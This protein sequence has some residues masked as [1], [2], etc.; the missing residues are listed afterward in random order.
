V[1]SLTC[2]HSATCFLICVGRIGIAI[3]PR[4]W[5]AD[6]Y[7][8]NVSFGGVVTGNQLSGAFGYGIAASSAR[9]FTIQDNTLVGNTTFIGSRGPNCSTTDITPSPGP[10]VIQ[11]NNTQNMKVQGN[12]QTIPDGDGLT[13]ILPPD[14]GDYWPFG[15]NPSGGGG[16]SGSDGS[17]S[18]NGGHSGGGLSGGAKAGI[19]LGVI[20]GLLAIG[21]ATFVVRRRAIAAQRRRE[22]MESGRYAPKTQ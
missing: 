10:F 17:S 9:D 15:G 11:Q 5:F 2:I 1:R 3:G 19:A 16:N 13:C 18:P 4:T 6:R 14:G 20:F 22:A 8:G 21:L 12:F 7:F